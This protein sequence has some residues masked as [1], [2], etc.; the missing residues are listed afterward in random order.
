[1]TDYNNIK[2]V[3]PSSEEELWL[4]QTLRDGRDRRRN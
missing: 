3:T 2:W 1:M 4:L